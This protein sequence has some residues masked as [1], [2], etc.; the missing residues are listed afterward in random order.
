MQLLGLKAAPAAP[1]HRYLLLSSDAAAAD[2]GS[3]WTTVLEAAGGGLHAAALPGM[4]LEA[5]TLL[6]SP[7]PGGSML[8]VTSQVSSPLP[9]CCA[10]V[11]H[12]AGAPDT[13]ARS[14][15]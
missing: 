3:G 8:Q 12:A 6:A 4:Q 11:P 5:A 15:W 13:R 1:T 14:F 2:A 10:S 9:V 7:L